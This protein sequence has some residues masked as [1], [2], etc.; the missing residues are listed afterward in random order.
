MHTVCVVY[1]SSASISTCSFLR[2]CCPPRSP[3]RPIRSTLLDPWSFLSWAASS[4][5]IPGASTRNQSYLFAI[6]GGHTVLYEWVWMKQ[7]MVRCTYLVVGREGNARRWFAR[8][9]RRGD[10]VGFRFHSRSLHAKS[11]TAKITHSSASSSSSQRFPV[12]TSQ[13][14]KK[15][16]KSLLL[17]NKNQKERR[18][19]SYLCMLIVFSTSNACTFQLRCFGFRLEGHLLITCKYFCSI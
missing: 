4:G 5:F 11:T 17:S 9:A 12:P 1:I 15:H 10:V 18:H 19:M 16:T 7:A 8:W 2:R 6:G 13:P 14:V 3:W